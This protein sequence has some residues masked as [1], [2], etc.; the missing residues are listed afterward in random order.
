MLRLQSPVKEGKEIRIPGPTKPIA[1]PIFYL[2]VPWINFV[3]QSV[4]GLALC[5]AC[6]GCARD[7]K[8]HKVGF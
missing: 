7:V 4:A 3:T 6:I 8:V 1:P 5:V 2:R